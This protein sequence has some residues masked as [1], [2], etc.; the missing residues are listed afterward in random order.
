MSDPQRRGQGG[1]IYGTT[2]VSST[3]KRTRKRG[4]NR[5]PQSKSVS[6][7]IYND[8][9]SSSNRQSSSTERSYFAGSS[10][11]DS[12]GRSLFSWNGKEGEG[13]SYNGAPPGSRRRIVSRK[14]TTKTTTKI[15]KTHF[16]GKTGDPNT[17]YTYT[18]NKPGSSITT[19]KN[20]TTFV[21]HSGQ[22]SSR[23][24]ISREHKYSLD[25]NIR[26]GDGSSVRKG[27]SGVS[28]AEDTYG[29]NFKVGVG[30]DYLKRTE[31]DIVYDYEEEE[32]D[33]EFAK[34][35][36]LDPNDQ[37]HPFVIRGFGQTR[38]NKNPS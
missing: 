35:P 15:T 26:R 12:E 22:E 8:S 3:K 18:Y 38:G 34:G 30:E 2:R 4:K 5:H 28:I 23:G 27:S 31:E 10:G 33:A 21:T 13:G 36:V 9:Y 24:E 19:Y 6:T 14:K 37:Y 29:P 16:D 32:F 17:S 7:L 11:T 20:L 25:K 1:V